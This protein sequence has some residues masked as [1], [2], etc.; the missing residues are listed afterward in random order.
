MNLRLGHVHN[1]SG[2][3]ARVDDRS[4]TVLEHVATRGL[5]SEEH[6]MHVE[7]DHPMPVFNGQVFR[8][9]VVRHP[10]IVESDV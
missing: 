3:G 6:R 1:R 8:R 7:V 5:R 2:H 10:S 9:N 4:T